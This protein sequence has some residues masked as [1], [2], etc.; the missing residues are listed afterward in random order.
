[1]NSANGPLIH[2]YDVHFAYERGLD[3]LCGVHLE[4][5]EGERVGLVGGNGSGKTT[6]LHILV[7]LLTPSRGKVKMFGRNRM[8]ERDFRE[9]RE[10]AGL[11]FQDPQDQLFCPTVYEDVAFGPLNLGKSREEVEE[12]VEKVLSR[13]DLQGYEER[14]TYKLSGGEKRLVSLACV[15]A[16]EPEVLLLDEPAEGLDE[17]MWD[18]L[19]DILTELPQSMIIVSHDRQFL[20]RTTDR[21]LTLK[22]GQLEPFELSQRIA[23]IR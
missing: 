10:R 5:G 3:V 19:V 4:L 2:L 18:R 20:R 11:L 7:G 6:L 9:V 16:M 8:G 13:L 12:V 15:L 17:G 23:H 21:V 1:M 22:G 14:I